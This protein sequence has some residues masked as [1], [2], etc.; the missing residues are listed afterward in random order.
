FLNSLLQD[1]VAQLR[2]VAVWVLGERKDRATRH[3]LLAAVNDQDEMVRSVAVWALRSL[4]EGSVWASSSEDR[5]L[6]PLGTRGRLG[7]GLDKQ[8]FMLHLLSALMEYFGDKRGYIHP[9]L[10]ES[11]SGRVLVLWCYCQGEGSS[12]K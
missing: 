8:S 12:L 4:G 5:Q 7:G 6:T 10:K 1:E 3:S 11:S 2:A 9:E